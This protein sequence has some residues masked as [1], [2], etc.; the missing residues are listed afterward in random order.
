MS[1]FD[2][3]RDRNQKAQRDCNIT[4]DNWEKN[5][6]EIIRVSEI[7]HNPDFIINDL[8]SKFEKATKLSCKRYYKS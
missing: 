2:E 7:V 4:I 1:R 5:S 6:D 3:L 8:D